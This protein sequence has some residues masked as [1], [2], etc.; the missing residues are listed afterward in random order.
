MSN[1]QNESQDQ[2]VRIKQLQNEL[3]NYIRSNKTSVQIGDEYER[4][5]G[6]LC[7]KKGYYVNYKGLKE[8]YEDE[9]IDL[10]AKDKDQILLI[11]C[12][13]WK[14]SSTINSDIVDQLS[15]TRNNYSK[16]AQIPE[17]KI[18][19]ILITSARVSDI[20]MTHAKNNNI[21]IV[22]N[23]QPR[24]YPMIKCY[25]LY[26]SG[27]YQKFYR[28]PFDLD[29]DEIHTTKYVWTVEEAEL[30]GFRRETSLVRKY[31][32]PSIRRIQ[33]STTGTYHKANISDEEWQKIRSQT[34]TTGTPPLAVVE[35]K[36]AKNSSVLPETVQAPVCKPVSPARTSSTPTKEPK[37][38][39]KEPRKNT[40]KAKKY[41]FTAVLLLIII[42]ILYKL[43]NGTINLLE[44]I[45]ALLMFWYC[46]ALL[47]TITYDFLAAIFIDLPFVAL[48]SIFNVKI[49]EEVIENIKLTVSILF[50]VYIV[51]RL[52]F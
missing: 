3:E 11:Q 50:D 2:Q 34:Y 28:L 36:P 45:A 27:K 35:P 20:G 37:K 8:R 46:F 6:Y 7:S 18:K 51:L 12:K 4:Y 33:T 40:S 30:S 22:Q 9:G 24:P 14:K 29:Y 47:F 38:A 10:I 31:S 49:P 23:F 48:E 25:T 15:G 26:I 21:I 17:D 32:S 5:I 43:T 1:E 16:V 39:K 19:A 13:K 52:L 42:L 41:L 44:A